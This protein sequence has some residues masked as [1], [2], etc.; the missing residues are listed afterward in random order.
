MLCGICEIT[1][2]SK[3]QDLETEREWN[4]NYN[5]FGQGWSW[6]VDKVTFW[7][8]SSH[9][10]NRILVTIY[11]DDGEIHMGRLYVWS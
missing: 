10:E 2:E 9:A 1:V 6:L 5:S 3:I 8:D 11:M 4:F 7:E